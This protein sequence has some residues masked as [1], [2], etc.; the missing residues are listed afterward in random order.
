MEQLV[1]TDASEVGLAV[2]FLFPRACLNVEK[3]KKQICWTIM[4]LT[5]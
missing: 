4:G 2:L 1:G 3:K 5:V